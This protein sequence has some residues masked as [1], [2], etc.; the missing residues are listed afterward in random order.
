MYDY[1]L[2][3]HETLIAKGSVK[4]LRDVCR[5]IAMFSDNY[6]SDVTAYVWDEKGNHIGGYRDGDYHGDL[7]TY[8][9]VYGAKLWN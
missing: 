5:I 6:I 9:H 3:I 8:M 7:N 4:W 1:E 2:I